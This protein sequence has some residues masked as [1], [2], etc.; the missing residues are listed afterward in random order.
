[1]LAHKMQCTSALAIGFGTLRTS[2]AEQT[3][4]T[5]QGAAGVDAREHGAVGRLRSVGESN[6]SVWAT[7]SQPTLIPGCGPDHVA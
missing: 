4:S 6:A 3:A 7:A 5:V 2:A 1:M